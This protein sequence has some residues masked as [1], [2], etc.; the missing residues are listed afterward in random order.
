MMN[1][2]VN[3]AMPHVMPHV[4][5]TVNRYGGPV[6]LAGKIIGLSNDEVAAGIPWWTWVA[7]GVGV[8]AVATYML[9]NKIEKVVG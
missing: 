2:I 7:M 4:G 8:G 6:G 9:R 5:P 3:A 1:H